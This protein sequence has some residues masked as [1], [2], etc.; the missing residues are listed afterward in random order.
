[1]KNFSR[2]EIVSVVKTLESSQL[3]LPRAMLSS[4]CTREKSVINKQLPLA[5]ALKMATTIGKQVG[6]PPELILGITSQESRTNLNVGTKPY[7]ENCNIYNKDTKEDKA[8]RAQCN[9]YYSIINR[10]N[11]G[12]QFAPASAPEWATYADGVN[13]G[14]MGISQFKP[15]TWTTAVDK[16][17]GLENVTI[18]LGENW[19]NMSP[20]NPCV[21][22]VVS[23][24]HLA[25]LK[26]FVQREY[27]NVVS[28]ECL[29]KYITQIY[30]AGEVSKDSDRS[31]GIIDL[32]EYSNQSYYRR[33]CFKALYMG[34]NWA[35]KNYAQC[36]E[37]N[38]VYST[39]YSFD[40][41][42]SA[43]LLYKK[44]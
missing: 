7:V 15:L 9:E 24:S 25:Y 42:S 26:N 5:N 44:K 22:M 23:A 20:W 29:H 34:I 32:D 3:T 43:A 1:V 11:I 21:G 27:P 39:E 31:C 36:Y 19:A 13:G 17:N 14:A 6:L 41:A 8:K 2:Y 18:L 40:T 10:V 28:E 4:L 12:R 16:Q 30:Y 38:N 35:G 33:N 37:K